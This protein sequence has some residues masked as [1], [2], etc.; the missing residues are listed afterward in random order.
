MIRIHRRKIDELRRVVIPQQAL[1]GINVKPGELVNIS[2]EGGSIRIEKNR[3]T[4]WLCMSDEDLVEVEIEE[5]N[6][7]ICSRCIMRIQMALLRRQ[8]RLKKCCAFE[9]AEEIAE[10][11]AQQETEE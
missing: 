9:A 10:E 1:N 11:T 8:K 6:C 4:C 3:P 2:C 7:M 5:Q